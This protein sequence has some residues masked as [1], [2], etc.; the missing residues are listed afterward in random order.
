M[1]R[2]RMIKPE[3]FDDPDIA[4]V[5]PL[6]RLFFIGL[7]T[8]ADREGRVVDDS[9]R[10]KARIFPYE[11]A[12]VEALAVELHGKD[13]IRRYSDGQGKRF[14]W[15][16]TF[17]KHQRPHPKEPASVMPEWTA[18]NAKRHGEP[19]K[20][21]AGTSESGVLVLDPLESNGTR[22]LELKAAPAAR[23]PV[24]G[25]R[26]EERNVRI[27]TKIA[28]EVLNS[29]GHRADSDAMEAIKTLCA[30]RKIAYD[31]E[32]VRKALDSAEA[33]TS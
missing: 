8:E 33:Q 24:S 16:R 32:A 13:L 3:F 7:W 29:N 4:D 25:K 15:I 18:T 23:K 21:T 6:A 31:S 12:D 1:A 5:S 9:R 28:H 20:K 27:I 19:W 2:I 17:T 11:A 30:K 22:N 14:L 10:L 26:E